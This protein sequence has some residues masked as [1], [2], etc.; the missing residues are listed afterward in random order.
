MI[1]ASSAS[2][3]PLTLRRIDAVKTANHRLTR[4]HR[5]SCPLPDCHEA[6]LVIRACQGPRRGFERGLPLSTRFGPAVV[7]DYGPL[8]LAC[9]GVDVSRAGTP[10]AQL[11]L[12]RYGFACLPP[13]FH[14][15]LGDPSVTD[16]AEPSLTRGSAI[17]ADLLLRTR[18]IRLTMRLLMTAP[19]MHAL[20]DSSAW[21]RLAPSPPYHAWLASIAM[22]VRLVVGT[23]ALTLAESARLAC[24]D[25]VRVEH[26]VFDATGYAVVRIA[27]HRVH[28]RWIDGHHCFE[29]ENMSHDTSSNSFEQAADGTTGT[30]GA[31]SSIDTA[32]IPIRLSFVLGSLSLTVGDI[33]ELAPGSLLKLES[34]LPPR[35]TIEANGLPIGTGELVDLDGQLA[36]EITRWPSP[37]APAP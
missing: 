18:S 23:T 12:A 28:L 30:T 37:P 32:A 9:S 24:G 1:A 29:I 11:A 6:E 2:P 16:T 5:T 33:A 10:E 4:P 22:P 27:S 36:V 13:A 7:L 20:L 17:A 8:L 34:G 25:V 15:L 35:V 26:G 31:S 21:Q 19:G 14:S 3:A